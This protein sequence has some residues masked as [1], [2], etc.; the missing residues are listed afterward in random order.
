LQ[1]LGALW[2]VSG[3]DLDQ[4]QKHLQFARRNLNSASFPTAE[5]ISMHAHFFSGLRLR[6]TGPLP[7]PL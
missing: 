6:E 4:P 7:R 5:R 3:I 1:R 2:D